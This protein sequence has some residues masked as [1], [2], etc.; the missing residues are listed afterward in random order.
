[1]AWI[2]INLCL[3]IKMPDTVPNDALAVTSPERH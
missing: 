3:T 1:M 2:S